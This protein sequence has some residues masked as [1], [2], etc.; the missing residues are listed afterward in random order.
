MATELSVGDC[1]PTSLDVSYQRYSDWCQ[2]LGHK[3]SNW[4]TWL[5]LEKHGF[6]GRLGSLCQSGGEHEA[7]KAA[8][9]ARLDSEMAAA[10]RPYQ[11]SL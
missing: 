4:Q 10:M 3:P 6:R 7:A 1:C 11:D 8:Y 5:Q 2:R 9:R